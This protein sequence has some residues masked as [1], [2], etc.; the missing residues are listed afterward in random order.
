MENAS[1]STGTHKDGERA[2]NPHL[3]SNALPI[4]PFA[5]AHIHKIGINYLGITDI[6]KS[7]VISESNRV[8]SEA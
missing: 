1:I 3:G 2:V 5:G 4:D 7:H 8:K 6:G